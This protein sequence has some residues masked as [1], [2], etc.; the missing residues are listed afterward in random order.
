MTKRETIERFLELLERFS[1]DASDYRTVLHPEIE[2]TEYPNQLTD[3]TVVSDFSRLME[4][5]PNGK[6]LLREQKYDIRRIHETDESLIAEVDWTAIVAADAG[7]FRAGQ[8]LTAY[9]CAVFDFKDGKI[10]RQRNYDC[11]ERF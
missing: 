3:R 5:I 2:Q 8:A 9:I 4:R 1:A 7:P 6:R 10:Y 11:F